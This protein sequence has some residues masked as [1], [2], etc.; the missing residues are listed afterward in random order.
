MQEWRKTTDEN[1]RLKD[2]KIAEMQKKNEQSE[3]DVSKYKAEN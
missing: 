3:K 1:L 2:Q